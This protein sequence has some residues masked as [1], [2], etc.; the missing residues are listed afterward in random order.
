VLVLLV[1]CAFAMVL[2]AITTLAP[3]VGLVFG[4]ALMFKGI[5]QLATGFVPELGHEA[6]IAIGVVGGF[7]TLLA[8]AVLLVGRHAEAHAEPAPPVLPRARVVK[9]REHP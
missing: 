9:S 8:G 7:T 1:L 6:A 5:A 4:A 3:R 2:I